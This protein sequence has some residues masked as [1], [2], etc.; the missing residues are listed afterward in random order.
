MSRT[1]TVTIEQ[2]A[3]ALKATGGFITMAATKLNVTHSAVSQRVSKSK[4]LQKVITRIQA[5]NLDLSESG[6]IKH[7]KDENLNAIKYYLSNKGRERGYGQNIELTGKDGEPLLKPQVQIKV[8]YVE[9][10]HPD[11]ERSI[12]GEA[13]G[14]TEPI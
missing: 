11:I 7:L 4:K 5:E 6:L 13:E 1:P 2:I 10:G 12:P 14:A 8:E 9:A 3:Q